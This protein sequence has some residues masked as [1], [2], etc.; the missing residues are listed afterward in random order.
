[1]AIAIRVFAAVFALL[2]AVLGFVVIDLEVTIAPSAEWVPVVL[3]DGGWGLLVTFLIVAGFALVTV[4]PQWVDEIVPQVLVVAALIAGSGF[5]GAESAVWWM[6]LALLVQAGV[7]AGLAMIGRRRGVLAVAD[8]R[9]PAGSG[10]SWTLAVLATLGAVPWLVYAADM[11]AANR[12]RRWPTEITNEVNHWAVQGAFAVALVIF[13]A[14]AALRPTLRRFNAVRVATC[15]VYLGICSLRFPT[16]AA[17]LPT[18]W[19]VLAI[20]W[21]ALVVVCPFLD[22]GRRV[23]REPGALQIPGN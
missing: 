18:T 23:R 1:M 10:V 11:Y 22:R 3:L 7:L 6:V 17:A 9:R 4:R 8:V 19:A 14:V 20:G 15:A 2:W 16:V 5:L 12:E 21:G 13:T